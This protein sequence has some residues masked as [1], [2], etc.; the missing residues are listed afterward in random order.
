M[1]KNYNRNISK[2]RKILIFLTALI[3]S[4]TVNVSAQ[5]DAPTTYPTKKYE[6]NFYAA[7]GVFFDYGD[8]VNSWSH[9]MVLSKGVSYKLG[10]GLNY[11]FTDMLSVMGG[12]AYRRDWERAFVSFDGGSAD[13]FGFIDFPVVFQVH[14]KDTEQPNN[15]WMLGLGIVFSPCF[16]PDEYYFD[17]DPTSTNTLEDKAIIKNFYV[18]LMPCLG[19][20]KKHL[21]LGL[22]AN[23]GLC[24]V[25]K[26]YKGF[27]I[28]SKYLYNICAVVGVKF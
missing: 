20:E 3:I 9:E 24:D 7:F 14:L 17:D 5:E 15:K 13:C 8:D 18:S 10:Y 26:K 23:I 2:M 25:S 6:H 22:E 12:V 16:D 1:R 11:Y 19:Y 4:S 28:G 27:D 21:R